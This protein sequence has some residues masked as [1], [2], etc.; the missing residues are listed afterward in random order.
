[1]YEVYV[2]LPEVNTTGSTMPASILVTPHLP[3]LILIDRQ[4]RTLN[5]WE[6][7][8]PS[9][10]RIKAAHNRKREK[11]EHFTSNITNFTVNVEPFE[12]WAHQGYI[13]K[14]NKETI[15]HIH[16]YMKPNITLNHFMENISAIT[17]VSSYF[18]FNSREAKSGLIGLQVK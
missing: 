1:M 15:K 14:R 3:D 11:Y 7:T 5:V 13:N 10:T 4:R 8:V 6:L 17:L 18:N 12:I 9:E 2:Y 16:K